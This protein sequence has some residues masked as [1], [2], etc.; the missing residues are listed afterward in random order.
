[1]L[2]LLVI[3]CGGPDSARCRAMSGLLAGRTRGDAADALLDFTPKA[4]T[5]SGPDF[6]TAVG[7]WIKYM[8]KARS[9]L[10]EKLVLFWHDHFAT[11]FAKVQNVG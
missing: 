8:W 5:P 6:A 2:R 9:P 7:K 4:F 3:S 10:Q 11:G 1:M